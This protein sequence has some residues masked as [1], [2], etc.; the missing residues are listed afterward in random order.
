MLSRFLI[1]CVLCLALGSAARAADEPR[2]V[3]EGVWFRVVCHFEHDRAADDALAAVEAIGPLA[4]RLYGLRTPT[5]DDLLEVHLYRTVADYEAAEEALTGG[6]F[7]RNLAFAHHE[8]RTAHV[9]V[10]PPVSEEVLD[11]L[12][13]PH[14]TQNLLAHEASHIVRF[15]AMPSF[16]SHP[17]WVVDG[18][19]IWLA[20][21]GELARG[22]IE[23][24]EACPLSATEICH[25]QRL[26]AQD[27]LPTAAELFH[28]RTE[29]LS[30]YERYASRW[31]FF[32]FLA[33]GPYAE[34]FGR[35][36]HKLRQM[37]GGADFADRFEARVVAATAPAETLDAAFRTWLTQQTPAWREV[38]RALDTHG[39]AWVQ[40]AWPDRNAISWRTVPAGSRRYTLA[41]RLE[42]LPG[43]NAQMNA[44]LDHT[45][46]GFVSVAMRSD[47][48]I[49]VF[50]YESADD[51][52]NRRGAVE[53][54]RL[55]TQG[56]VAFRVRVEEER[57]TVFVEDEEALVV[58]LAGRAMDGPWGLGAQW[59]TC[60][61]WH[62]VA[63]TSLGPVEK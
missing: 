48:W 49:T 63:L 39:A 5:P 62:D 26:L 57:V 50:E 56:P 23:S 3:R 19:A 7:K 37:G 45:E 29:E 54:A 32:H 53:H 13:L 59:G 55:K 33:A 10:Q 27:R 9:A 25:G 30:F 20:V 46:S 51:R 16:R 58:E 8:S 40:A 28:D 22:R 52:W 38:I 61:L 34:G 21:Q 35:A 60:G 4:A 44:L 15:R 2:T 43:A 17:M 1:P 47:G 36:L 6:A 18:A 12:G 42:I 24:T 31:L 11:R 14:L 41:G